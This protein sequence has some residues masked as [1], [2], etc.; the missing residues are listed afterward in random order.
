MSAL[1]RG[2]TVLQN[3]FL[4]L[5]ISSSKAHWPT[6]S[7]LLPRL[8]PCMFFFKLLCHCDGIHC[9]NFTEA[10]QMQVPCLYAKLK[11]HNPPPPF[12]FSNYSAP[13]IATVRAK[14]MFLVLIIVPKRSMKQKLLQPVSPLPKASYSLKCQCYCL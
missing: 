2:D 11:L 6:M 10:K 5:R 12:F 1:R 3:R 7:P 9:E 8:S 13:S 4:L 14:V